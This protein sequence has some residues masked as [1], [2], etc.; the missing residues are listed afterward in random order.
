M[1]AI[2]TRNDSPE[3]LRVLLV[4][5]GWICYGRRCRV[6]GIGE[7]EHAL[8][9]GAKIYGEVAVTGIVCGCLSSYQRLILTV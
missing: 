1:N 6:F 2:S 7:M 5:A 4:Q 9:R 8:A 3:P